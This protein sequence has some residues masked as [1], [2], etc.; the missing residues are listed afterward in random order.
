MVL[1]GGL[2]CFSSSRQDWAPNVKG[3]IAQALKLGL[4]GVRIPDS[5][6][7]SQVTF[8]ARCLGTLYFCC[9]ICGTDSYNTASF[10]ECLL[11]LHERIHIKG[12]C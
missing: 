3:N 4:T 8:S 5:A 6:A 2:L 9:L 12:P 7:F 11:G 1:Y 10:L